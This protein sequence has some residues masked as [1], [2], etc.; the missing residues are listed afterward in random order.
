MAP[1]AS[2]PFIWALTK[3]A[4]VKLAPTI[5]TPRISA[6]LKSEPE[7]LE[8]TSSAPRSLAPTR[9]ALRKVAP[10]KVAPDRS[11]PDSSHR[12]QL[13]P[14]ETMRATSRSWIEI[15]STAPAKA[16]PAAMSVATAPDR[17]EA[18]KA[19]RRKGDSECFITLS[20][21]ALALKNPT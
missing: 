15:M 6:R 4:P 18:T 1:V 17:A 8:P 12:L 11:R 14:R 20:E 9:V 16:G 5:W 21:C 3:V 19:R 10:V 2:A 13:P 7:K